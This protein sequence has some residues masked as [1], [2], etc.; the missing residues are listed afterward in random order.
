MDKD[1]NKDIKETWR[2]IITEKGEFKDYQ[3][4]N[5]GRVK[6]LKYG[7][8]RILKEFTDGEGYKVVCLCRD[9]KMTKYRLH[10]LLGLMFIPNIMDYPEVEHINCIPDDNRIKNLRW[11]SHR[12]NMNNEITRKRM[13]EAKKRKKE[14]I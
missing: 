1:T 12:G 14:G 5:L 4:S 10:R 2:V 6:S 9:N 13:S 11:N 3:I 8:E 7:K